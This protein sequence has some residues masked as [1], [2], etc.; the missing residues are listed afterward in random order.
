MTY[1]EVLSFLCSSHDI[2]INTEYIQQCNAYVSIS[3]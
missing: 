3:N 2:T 1:N